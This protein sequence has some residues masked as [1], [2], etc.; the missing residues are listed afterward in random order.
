MSHRKRSPLQTICLIKV[1]QGGQV[2]RSN[3][4][5]GAQA[6]PLVFAQELAHVTVRGGAGGVLVGLWGGGYVIVKCNVH[7]GNRYGN[8]VGRLAC[9]AMQLPDCNLSG[10][11]QNRRHML[12][13]R[14]SSWSLLLTEIISKV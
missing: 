3:D 1:N 6:D 2:T 12:A 14:S 9:E 7:I 5:L 8:G 13:G 11:E 10:S 4:Y